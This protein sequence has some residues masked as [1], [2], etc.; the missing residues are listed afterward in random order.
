MSEGKKSTPFLLR[1]YPCPLDRYSCIDFLRYS[2]GALM[3]NQF[4]YNDP[5]FQGTTLLGYYSFAGADKFRYLGFLA[6]FWL[7]FFLMT[8]F[9]MSVKKYQSR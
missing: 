1:P 4:E 8:W 3:L 5:S 7:F 9:T 2:F 6:L